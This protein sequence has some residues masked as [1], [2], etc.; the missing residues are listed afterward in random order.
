MATR[1]AG[2]AHEMG[3]AKYKNRIHKESKI[4]DD[5][6]N[7]PYKFSRPPRAGK[8]RNVYFECVACG[9]ESAVT[10]DT[11]LVICGGCKHLNRVKDSKRKD[12]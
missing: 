10:E 4:A 1:E 11:I 2:N 6:K 8:P 9:H 5:Q 7:L 12:S 3:I